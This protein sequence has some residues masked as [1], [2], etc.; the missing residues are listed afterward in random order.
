MDRIPLFISLGVVLGC[1]SAVAA[2]QRWRGQ[3]S[4]AMCGAD[5]G[6]MKHEGKKMSS[7]DCTLECVKDGGKFVLVSRGKVYNIANQDLKEFQQHAGHTVDL[8]GQMSA[9]GKMITATTIRMPG[10]KTSVFGKT[11]SKAPDSSGTDSTQDTHGGK[12][13]PAPPARR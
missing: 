11:K 12:T 6:M 9:D 4:D 13:P 8:T 2:E 3:I 1:A 7:R 10:S 5:H